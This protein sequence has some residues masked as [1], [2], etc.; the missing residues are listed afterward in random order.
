[1][2]APPMATCRPL[3]SL[4]PAQKRSRGLVC[5]GGPLAFTRRAVHRGRQD[6]EQSNY[7]MFA[8]SDDGKRWEDK[9]TWYGG[10]PGADNQPTVLYDPAQ[11]DW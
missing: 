1:M 3:R 6:G 4:R 10:D 2:T 5:D 9:A 8:A 7:L 11:N